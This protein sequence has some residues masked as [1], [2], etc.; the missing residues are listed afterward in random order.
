M[1][2]VIHRVPAH[3]C[4]IYIVVLSYTGI[5]KARSQY[6]K[7]MSIVRGTLACIVVTIASLCFIKD[8]SARVV[9]AGVIE[10]QVQPFSGIRDAVMNSRRTLGRARS[11]NALRR[12]NRSV[13]MRTLGGITIFWGGMVSGARASSVCGSCIECI[14]ANGVRGNGSI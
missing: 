3:R 2:C 9:G 12:C 4:K 5:T 13:R 11:S 7:M 8:A 14:Y 6:R 1:S 10:R